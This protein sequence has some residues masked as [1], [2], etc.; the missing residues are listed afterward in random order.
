M[1]LRSRSRRVL[2]GLALRCRA[3]RSR[4]T[5]R[6]PCGWSRRPGPRRQLSSTATCPVQGDFERPVHRLQRAR[7]RSWSA[8]CRGSRTVVQAVYERMPMPRA[9]YFAHQAGVSVD[10]DALLR[11]PRPAVL[12]R[13]GRLPGGTQPAAY[14]DGAPWRGSGWPATCSGLRHDAWTRWPTAVLLRARRGRRRRLRALAAGSG[15]RA[16]WRPSRRGSR[17]VAAELDTVLTHAPNGRLQSFDRGTG[18]SR[19]AAGLP[20]RPERR[21]VASDAAQTVSTSLPVVCPISPA[22]CAW[23]GALQRERLGDQHPQPPVVDEPGELLQPVAVRLDQHAGGAQPALGRGGHRVR[24]GRRGQAD[25]PAVGA[26]HVQRA[27]GDVA[28]DEVAARRR[29]ARSP[30]RTPRRGSRR[31]RRC[32]GRAA[33]RACPPTRCRSRT[34]R[35]PSRSARRGARRRRPRRAPAPAGRAAGRRCRPGTATRSARPAAARPPPPRTAGPGGA[36]SAATA[37]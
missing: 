3:R 27:H 26:Q 7:E 35:G 23:R 8:C 29:P 25:Q 36:R 22:R 28:A 15:A 32:R 13:P 14:A 31:P 4:T 6:G 10:T 5:D 2:A 16:T 19:T 20:A 21:S 34:R 24:R 1:R 30:A 33:G 12:P 18:E 37:R 17:R 9:C 11:A